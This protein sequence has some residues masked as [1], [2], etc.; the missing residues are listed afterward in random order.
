M[1][2]NDTPP[3]S[4]KDPKAGRKVKQQK[5]KIMKAR[6]FNPNTSKVGERIGVPR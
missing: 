5:N 4:L 6:S 3:N 2:S 1:G